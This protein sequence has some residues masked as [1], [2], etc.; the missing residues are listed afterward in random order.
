MRLVTDNMP[1]AMAHLNRHERYLFANAGFLESFGVSL[2]DIVGRSISSLL[3]PTDYAQPSRT[4]TGSRRRAPA[5][6]AQSSDG[7]ARHELVEFIPDRQ[8]RATS[9]AS[10]RSCT[11]SPTCTPRRRR[12]RQASSGCSGITES[13]PRWSATSTAS[14]ATASTAATTRVARQ[15]ASERSPGGRQRG[16]RPAHLRD[17]DGPHL[18]RAFAG[19]RVDF[20]VEATATERSLRFVRGSYVPDMDA[21]GPVVGVYSRNRHHV[22]QGGRAPA[23]AARAEGHADR[24]AQP[25]RVQRRHRGGAAPVAATG[26]AGGP[27]V[28]RRGRLQEDQRHARP[29]GRRRRVARIR[30]PAGKPAYARRISWRGLPATNSSSSW[31]AFTRATNAASSRGRSSRRCGPS[32]GVADTMVRITTSIGVALGHGA[33]TTPEAL[34]KRADSAL[35]AAKGHGRDRFEIAI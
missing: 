11:T 14:A 21:S 27:A 12:S 19:E 26:N 34:L 5:F 29:C 23:R 25:G 20:E 30:A 15:A 10:S 2:D 22:A 1:A 17:V 33:A 24:L 7:P 13:I 35:Y 16:P 32:S 6:P 8:Q 28:P 18:D 31:K 4:S 9:S 3:A